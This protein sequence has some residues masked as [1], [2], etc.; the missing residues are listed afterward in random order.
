M[1][2]LSGTRMTRITATLCATVVVMITVTH[3][4]RAEGPLARAALDLCLAALPAVNHGEALARGIALAEQAVAADETDAT[5]HLALFCNLGRQMQMRGARW[6]TLVELRRVRRE[7]DRTLDIEPNHI[8][9]LVAKAALLLELPG[10]LG[11]DAQ[12]AERLV[13]RAVELDPNHLP[14]RQYLTRALEAQGKRAD[15]P[16]GLGALDHES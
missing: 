2:A 12:E 5:A 13:R 9:A 16:T 6:S 3:S 8:D 15:A 14:A 11:G 1:G 10:L 4:V 7:I